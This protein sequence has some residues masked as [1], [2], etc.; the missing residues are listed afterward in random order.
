MHTAGVLPPDAPNPRDEIEARVR[1]LHF[2]VFGLR[3]QP[4]IEDWGAVGIGEMSDS[5]VTSQVEVSIGY[6]LWRQ[7]DDRADPRNLADLDEQT[8]AALDVDPPW[9]RPEW[10]VEAAHRMRFPQV[11]SAVRT[12]WNRDPSELTT[13]PFQLVQHA[14][15][16]L[17]NEFREEL[18]LGQGHERITK[19]GWN[20]SESAVNPAAALEI[21]GVMHAAMEV[22]TDPF[23]YAIGAEITRDVA[24]T[25]AVSREYLP[26]LELALA[27]RAPR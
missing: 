9:P 8:L 18:G 21:D 13:L 25:V 5:R 3:P 4:S 27:T 17:M 6:T 10:L 16:I 24:V 26:H 2:P 20:V 15:Y 11:W 14:N 12:T 7:P 22:D 1:A 19:T 23:V